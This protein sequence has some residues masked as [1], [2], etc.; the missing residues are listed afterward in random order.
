ML[1][2]YFF[3]QFRYGRKTNHLELLIRIVHTCSGC[4][5]CENLAK[6]RFLPL[7]QPQLINTILIRKMRWCV[8]MS[9]GDLKHHF[10][11]LV[12]CQGIICGIED[13]SSKVH[14][15]GRI[16]EIQSSHESFCILELS[17]IPQ[18]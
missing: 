15:S 13:P 12:Q 7:W 2:I 5:S 10:L 16:S 14:I 18:I 3:K 11:L 9:K 1:M 17:V 6:A 4:R 8:C